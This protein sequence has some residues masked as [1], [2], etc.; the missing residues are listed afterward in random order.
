MVQ[1]QTSTKKEE[2]EILHSLLVIVLEDN[3]LQVIL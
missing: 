3:V 2:M 1:C